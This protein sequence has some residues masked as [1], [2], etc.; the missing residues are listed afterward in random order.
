MLG[1]R[2]EANAPVPISAESGGTVTGVV[3]WIG[4]R[5]FLGVT[6][7][8]TRYF[9]AANGVPGPVTMTLR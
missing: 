9:P 7:A 2:R 1:P 4:S 6:S 8:R 5:A 3:A